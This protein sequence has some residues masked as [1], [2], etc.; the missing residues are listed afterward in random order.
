MIKGIAH[1][2]FQASTRH[3]SIRFYQNAFG[4]QPKFTLEDD[5]NKP[6]IVYLEVGNDQFIE[7][8]YAHQPL[9][10]QPN[11]SSYQHLCLEV[12][13]IQ[14]VAARLLEKG[15]PLDH[16]VGKRQQLSMLDAVHDPD[17]NPIE[18][19]NTVPDHYENNE[20]SR[21]FN[22]QKAVIEKAIRTGKVA[23]GIGRRLCDRPWI[24]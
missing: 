17:G 15:F 8:F 9:I 18:L 11:A 6:W 2:A 4:F 16:P 23:V 20:S 1:L 12:S 21:P 5:Q 10:R 22:Q 19:M 3:A 24:A 13:D 7:L 14:A